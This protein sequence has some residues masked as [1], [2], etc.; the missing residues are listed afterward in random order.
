MSLSIHP[1]RVLH[2]LEKQIRAD[3]AD[4]DFVPD[5]RIAPNTEI[6]LEVTRS[7]KYRFINSTGSI[8]MMQGN[9]AVKRW[10]NRQQDIRLFGL[11][12]NGNRLNRY[13]IHTA[14]PRSKPYRSVDTGII[15]PPMLSVPGHYEDHAHVDIVSAYFS[16]LRLVGIYPC[17]VWGKTLGVGKRLDSYPFASNKT[18]RNSLYGTAFNPRLAYLTR[19]AITTV[20]PEN[21]VSNPVMVQLVQCVMHRIAREARSLGAKQWYTDGGI[22]PL[23]NLEQFLHWTSTTYGLTLKVKSTGTMDVFNPSQYRT[24]I[25]E[26]KR[27][28]WTIRQTDTIDGYN[29]D[30]RYAEYEDWLIGKLRWWVRMRGQPGI[31]YCEQ[32]DKPAT[33]PIEA[34]QDRAVIQLPLIDTPIQLYA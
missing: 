31:I 30:Y 25:H 16:V 10:Y 17:V 26:P 33:Q 20:R 4:C 8:T 32:P 28:R 5:M 29:G 19:G 21:K 24:P 2:L 18:V 12:D 1:D 9:N 14:F 27:T 22:I 23:E 11:H 34:R 7:G 6:Q 15:L 3:H 13:W